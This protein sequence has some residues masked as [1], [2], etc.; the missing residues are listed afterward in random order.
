M[1][2]R[3]DAEDESGRGDGAS[4]PVRRRAQRQPQPDQREPDRER[5]RGHPGAHAKRDLAAGLTLRDHER[6]TTDREHHR[7]RRAG[8]AAD[9]VSGVSDATLGEE[10]AGG[11]R[12]E[13]ALARRD[14]RAE[15]AHPQRQIQ[16]ERGSA[17]DSGVGDAT[18]HDLAQR[19][20]H[21]AAEGERREGVLG[22]SRNPRIY[23]WVLR[24]AS[25]SRT[26]AS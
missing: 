2:R 22:A 3:Q 12:E 16:R 15:Q 4:D 6:Q 11:E 24:K 23:F 14:G 1:V 9:D 8:E 7:D 10:L 26:A 17:G 25:R 13:L 18:K 5:E 21:D 19:Q 20:Q